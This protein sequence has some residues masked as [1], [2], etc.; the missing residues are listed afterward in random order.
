MLIQ[1]WKFCCFTKAPSASALNFKYEQPQQETPRI[2][3]AATTI[4]SQSASA[5]GS[6][7]KFTIG[8]LKA[9]LNSSSEFEMYKLF[10]QSH[11]AFFD[12][13]CYLDIESYM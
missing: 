7:L 8:H 3:S 13:Q 10:M 4:K 6:E 1:F 12:L 5:H 11:K 2:K 9:I